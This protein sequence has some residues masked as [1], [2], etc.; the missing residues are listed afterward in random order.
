[1]QILD[2]PDPED[3]PQTANAVLIGGGI[4]G[5]ATAFWLSRVGLDTVLVIMKANHPGVAKQP[6]NHPPQALSGRLGPDSCLNYAGRFP[7]ERRPGIPRL[8]G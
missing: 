3:F 4:A 8:S 5:T 1:M 7:G 2:F 6:W